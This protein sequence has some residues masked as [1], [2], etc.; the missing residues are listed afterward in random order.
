MGRNKDFD[1]HDDEDLDDFEDDPNIMTVN[2]AMEIGG[3]FKVL[4]DGEIEVDISN[5]PEAQK[6]IRKT[7]NLLKNS[8]PEDLLSDKSVYVDKDGEIKIK[9]VEGRKSRRERKRER[10]ARETKE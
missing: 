7:L 1:E 2:C 8:I 5:V 9:A 6:R 3:Q 10:Q 4:L